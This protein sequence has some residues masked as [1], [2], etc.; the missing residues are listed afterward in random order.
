MLHSNRKSTSLWLKLT[1]ILHP[2]LHILF[3]FACWFSVWFTLSR[4]NLANEIKPGSD[5]TEW[6]KPMLQST[7]AFPPPSM[8]CSCSVHP[9]VLLC[10][11]QVFVSCRECNPLKKYSYYA[12]NN[13]SQW[14][15]YHLHDTMR[16]IF[17]QGEFPIEVLGSYCS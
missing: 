10:S 7:L 15:N 3:K 14:I 9:T 2:L 1:F 11:G 4:P 13:K 5:K 8:Q 6:A 17:W 16:N 12:L